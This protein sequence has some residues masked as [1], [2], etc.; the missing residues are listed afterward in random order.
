M[1]TRVLTYDL[2]FGN[3]EDYATLYELIEQ[4][5]G[6]QITEST[7]LIKTTDDWETFMKKFKEVTNDGDNVKAIIL[8]DD[9]MKIKTIR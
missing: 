7:Y 4:Y 2:N 9:T 3:A 5:G 1:Y 8:V 6:Y